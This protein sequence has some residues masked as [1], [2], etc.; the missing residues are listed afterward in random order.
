MDL[1][2][3]DEDG[4]LI[5]SPEERSH[6]LM[7]AVKQVVWQVGGRAGYNK[8]HPYEDEGGELVVESD[9]PEETVQEAVEEFRDRLDEFR[10]AFESA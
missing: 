7:T 3:R 5:I 2:V 1:E 4:N 6:T 8:G 10:D 9:D